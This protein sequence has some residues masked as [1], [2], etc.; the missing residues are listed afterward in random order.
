M[1]PLV[2]LYAQHKNLKDELFSKIEEV[3]NKSAFIQ[4][5]YVEEFQ[6]SFASLLNVNYCVGCSSGTSALSIALEVLGIK[7]GDEVITTPL[8]FFATVE[9]IIHVKAK[10]V[11][12]D[13]DPLTFNIN[14]NNIEKVINE[15][16]RAIIPVHIYGNPVNMKKILELGS[17]YNLKIIEDCAQAHLAKIDDRYVG[18]FG[19]ISAFS[20]FPGKNIGAMGDAGAIVTNNR[21]YY[22]K[23][24]MLVDHGRREK[25]LHEMVG[26]NHRLDGLQAAILSVKLKYLREWTE[27]RIVNANL[28]KKLLSECN[29]VQFQQIEK[30]AIHVYHLFVI[31]IKKRDELIKYLKNEGINTSIHY[32]VPLHL[33]PALS[34]LG[35]KKG[36]LPVVEEVCN[37]ILSLPMYPELEKSKIEVICEKIK[38]FMEMY[39]V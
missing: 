10:P 37:E 21:E 13:I 3:I 32:P 17:K 9:A 16:T 31:R 8:T 18:T 27:K 34:Y 36:D 35:Y 11:F 26:Y 24:K 25:Y 7:E 29:N 1:I 30:N 6:E 19:D 39:N 28:Y 4:G 33:Q 2:D 5:E 12:V 15:K 22:E 38:N 20:F 23:S 14:V